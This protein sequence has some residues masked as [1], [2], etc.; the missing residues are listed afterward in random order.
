MKLASYDS[1]ELNDIPLTKLTLN[2]QM[3]WRQPVRN[4]VPLSIN[5]DGTPYNGGLGY[6]DDYRVRSG[7]AEAAHT[8]AT[9]TGY[10]PV[11]PGDVVRISGCDFDY[12]STGNAINASDSSFTNLGQ[13]VRNMT[14]YGIFA[15]S[16]EWYA[17]SMHSV[18]QESEG[19][20]RWVVPP[21]AS[22]VAWIRVTGT[23][24]GNG[25]GL[26]VTVSGS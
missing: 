10:I 15:T 3:I 1:L 22:G 23:T 20:W 16:G 13:L 9:C 5:A 21:A 7:G 4:Q 11:H 19:V 24:Q 12:V 18:V 14:G 8:G 25:A 2:G 26:C 6:K 17:Y